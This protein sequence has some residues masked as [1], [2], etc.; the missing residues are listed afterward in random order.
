MK[1][2]LVAIVVSLA[3]ICAP[4]LGCFAE[5]IPLETYDMTR[6]QVPST[7]IQ[8][9]QLSLEE[10]NDFTY[11]LPP[12][13]QPTTVPN[14]VS[15]TVQP[16]NVR[17]SP[18]SPPENIHK[19]PEKSSGSSLS[20]QTAVDQSHQPSG[21]NRPK[22]Q[23]SDIRDEAAEL[24]IISVTPEGDTLNP[25]IITVSFSEDMVSPTINFENNKII[26]LGI[27]MSP[28]I[29]GTWRWSTAR[30]LRFHPK[31]GR[32]PRST[33]YTVSV[34]KGLKSS[35]RNI[36]AQGK[37][38]NFSTQRP[39]FIPVHGAYS[40][41][42]KCVLLSFGQPVKITSLLSKVHMRFGEREI[43]LRLASKEE[44]KSLAGDFTGEGQYCLLPVQPLPTDMNGKV[45]VESGIE[46]VEGAL[47]SANSAEEP[48]HSD[49]DKLIC[50]HNTGSDNQPLMTELGHPWQITFEGPTNLANGLILDRSRMTKEMFA[51]TPKLADFKVTANGNQIFIRGSAQP[52][53]E[54]ML[55]I[56]PDLPGYKVRLGKELLVKLKAFVNS[57]NRSA[58][59]PISRGFVI[60]PDGPFKM[61]ILSAYCPSILATLYS[62]DQVYGPNTIPEMPYKSPPPET[63]PVL[64]ETLPCK[65]YANDLNISVLD[66]SA[67]A[68]SKQ[69]QYLLYVTIP[70]EYNPSQWTNERDGGPGERGRIRGQQLPPPEPKRWYKPV[71]GGVWVTWVQFISTNV[72]CLT[73]ANRTK[74]VCTDLNSGEIVD[75]LAA[76]ALP[77]TKMVKT[78]KGEFLMPSGMENRIHDGTSV[79]STSGKIALLPNRFQFSQSNYV[80]R[81]KF[82]FFCVGDF[83]HAKISKP[84]CFAGF[85]HRCDQ[86]GPPHAAPNG[87]LAFTCRDSEGLVIDS[88][89]V[90]LRNGFFKGE[91]RIPS[92]ANTGIGITR[93]DY[94]NPEGGS[95][96]FALQTKIELDNAIGESTSLTTEP[97]CLAIGLPES[98]TLTAHF[99]FASKN[100]PSPLSVGWDWYAVY[101]NY[102]PQGWNDFRFGYK[103]NRNCMGDYQW[104]QHSESSHNESAATFTYKN[105]SCFPLLFSIKAS[106]VD[107]KNSQTAT[108][109]NLLTPAS[110]LVGLQE[111]LKSEFGKTSIDLK[112]IVTDL[113]GTAIANNP[114]DIRILK[115]I[116]AQ[117]DL[118]NM[119]L[120]KLFCNLIN[121]TG[122]STFRCF[123]GY[124]TDYGRHGSR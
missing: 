90:E 86:F 4:T 80:E 32:L 94:K 34:P 54:Y 22:A 33:A 56:S 95:A 28:R 27:T 5:E 41:L 119:E 35:K 99:K 11:T 53:V 63:E 20:S 13:Q 42:G 89:Q 58:L 71:Y 73:S 118:E 60:P 24:S 96:A 115:D 104:C 109:T 112:T 44:C 68:K 120:A 62:V 116:G 66:L 26:N 92:S 17:S 106:T 6:A 88:G 72:T 67:L 39:E 51:I 65:P 121:R 101:A 87:P 48:I 117:S 49:P 45:E 3:L 15:I 69:T 105:N 110:L 102:A 30:V 122:Y 59:K 36:L 85:V 7:V 111:Q 91:F 75:A 113:S 93:F 77:D 81:S 31:M 100:L 10:F 107:Q 29:D 46:A 98:G 12:Y 43:P 23:S 25:G 82:Q 114:I 8:T 19:N 40:H 47:L 70:S 50:L 78:A 52:D 37:T 57:A 123:R 14:L 38:W 108:C 1:N 18:S 2:V 124:R 83:A 103:R 79:L 84:F 21:D 76:K 55:S 61:S 16:L 74:L 64:Q 97:T 9:E